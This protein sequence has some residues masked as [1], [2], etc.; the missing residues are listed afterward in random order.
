MHSSY[1]IPSPCE[2]LYLIIFP[3]RRLSTFHLIIYYY[4]FPLVLCLPFTSFMGWTVFFIF[5]PTVFM[6]S[7]SGSTVPHERFFLAE[8]WWL[9]AWRAHHDS[10]S[11]HSDSPGPLLNQVRM[12]GCRS[13]AYTAVK[14]DIQQEI[15][16]SRDWMRAFPPRGVGGLESSSRTNE[17]DRVHDKGEDTTPARGAS[18]DRLG[19]GFR[20]SSSV[21]EWRPS[22]CRCLRNVMD[23]AVLVVF[24]SF[25][26]CWGPTDV[27]ICT[28][29]HVEHHAP[30]SRPWLYRCD[31]MCFLEDP[32]FF[33]ES[34]RCRGNDPF[35]CRRI[36]RQPS[37]IAE[38]HR[39][40]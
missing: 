10:S 8:A 24:V 2:L 27:I 23:A 16:A 32:A 21:L 18:L 30:I 13:G 39:L 11:I 7:R 12:Y 36:R 35:V 15:L 22:R 33:S 5:C 19:E 20:L 31:M 9:S 25:S 26:L 40:S 14:T 3:P 34:R 38:Y 28:I 29:R 4:C 37:F 1:D 6:P 17:R